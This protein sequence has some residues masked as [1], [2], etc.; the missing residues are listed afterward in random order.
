MAAHYSRYID[1]GTEFRKI[2]PQYVNDLF[3]SSTMR[4]ASFTNNG[5]DDRWGASIRVREMAEK[6]GIVVESVAKVTWRLTA[7][8]SVATLM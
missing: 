4:F 3:H 2:Y 7:A 8:T 6:I 5:S 1:L